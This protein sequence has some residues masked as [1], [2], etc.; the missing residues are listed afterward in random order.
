MGQDA[1]NN[2]LEGL[3]IGHARRAEQARTEL[4]QQRLQNERDSKEAEIKIRHDS[5]D[6]QKRQFDAAQKVISAKAAL[7]SMQ[8]KQ[9]IAKGIMQGVPVPG[10]TQQPQGGTD[11]QPFSPIHPE[12]ATSVLHTLPTGDT[13]SIP[14]PQTQAKT[15]ASVY[16]IANK[17]VE[18][19]KTRTELA[20]QESKNQEDRNKLTEEFGRRQLDNANSLMRERE[21]RASAEKIALANNATQLQVAKIAHAGLSNIFGQSSPEQIKAMTDPVIQGMADGTMGY[22]SIKKMFADKGMA[23]GDALVTASFM[24][25]GMV[26]PSDKQVSFVQN[27]KPIVDSLPLIQQYINLLPKTT[28]GLGGVLAG[29]THPDILNPEL[30]ALMKQIQFNIAPVAKQLGGDQGQRL[31]KAL[32]EPAEGGY[33]PSKSKPTPANVS[34]FNKLVD[35]LDS[36]VD[37]SLGSLT[38]DQRNHI[39]ANTLGLNKISKLNPDG[40]P[41]VIQQQGQHPA[42]GQPAQLSPAAQQLMQ[43]HGIQ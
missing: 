7:D 2:I 42:A 24:K 20:L 8:Q 43:K 12:D 29:I 34:N 31:Q 16:E 6:E 13:V 40:S 3:K 10:A 41:K 1:I 14:T 38:P 28:T 21:T 25:N 5:L 39:K 33:F 11:Q 32:L 17:P 9:E 35:I 22:E 30:G 18:A 36:V 26:P 15:A 27:V 4:E 23:G 19:A 37:S